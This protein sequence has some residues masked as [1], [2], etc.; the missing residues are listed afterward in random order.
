MEVY[1]EDDD[2][3]LTDEL[4]HVHFKMIQSYKS[5]EEHTLIETFIK[6]YT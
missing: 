5:T 1:P 3:K 6:L 2:L 4:L